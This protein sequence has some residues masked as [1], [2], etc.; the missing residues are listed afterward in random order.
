MSGGARPIRAVLLDL[1]YTLVRWEVAEDRVQEHVD[2]GGLAIGQE[3][4]FDE[5]IDLLARQLRH[6]LE[7]HIHPRHVEHIEPGIDEILGIG[8]VDIA[9][10]VRRPDEPLGAERAERIDVA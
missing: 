2:R 6:L 3:G 1:G 10:E 4:G 7:I 9:A 8:L 5:I